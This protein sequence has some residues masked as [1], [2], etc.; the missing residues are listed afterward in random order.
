L[1][2]LPSGSGFSS[3]DLNCFGD[4]L[5]VF[6]LFLSV[7]EQLVP[8]TSPI[9]SRSPLLAFLDFFFFGFFCSY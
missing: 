7:I 2:D 4:W 6:D 9:V 8:P 3:A 5:L 1:F